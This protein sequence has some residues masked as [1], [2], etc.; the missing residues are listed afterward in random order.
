MRWGQTPI[1][2]YCAPVDM[3]KGFEGLAG[4]V[5]EQLQCDPLEGALFVFTNRRRTLAKVLWF[6]GSG[7][8]VMAKRLERGQFPALW[9]HTRRRSLALRRSELELFLEGS[10]LVGR[11]PVS[12]PMLS[13]RELA[14]GA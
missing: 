10:K 1:Y 3:R 12:P 8:C 14:P 13:Q 6:D 9:K 2:A 11:Y 4:L 5:R 7:L